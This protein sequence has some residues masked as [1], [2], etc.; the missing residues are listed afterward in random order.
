MATWFSVAGLAEFAK[1]ADWWVSTRLGTVGSVT[2]HTVV[3]R[4]LLAAVQT[5]GNGIEVHS[6]RINRGTATGARNAN[7]LS[8]P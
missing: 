1:Q 3:H 2:I 6:V 4:S 7:S 8:S 5:V